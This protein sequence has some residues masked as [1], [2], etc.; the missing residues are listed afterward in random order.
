M[1]IVVRSEMRWSRYAQP[2][3]Y[4]TLELVHHEVELVSRKQ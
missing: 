2:D 1:R 4:Y 3:K